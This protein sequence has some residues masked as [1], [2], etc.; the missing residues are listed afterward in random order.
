MPPTGL[1]PLTRVWESFGYDEI[2]WTYTPTG[3]RLL[4]T[5]ADF[6]GAQLPRPPALRLLLRQRLRH[7]AL[8]QRQRLP[9][10][11][12]RQ[13][14][15]R[16]HH[17]R[18]GLRRDRRRRS[19]R[20][21]RARL[22]SARPGAAGGRGAEG[23]AQPDRLHLLRGRH[24]GVPA[25]GLRQV[26]RPDRGARAALPGTLRRR[27]GH[28]LALG[29]VERARH[30]L[31]ARHAGTVQRAVHRHRASRSQR[32]TE[33]QG[34]RPDG[35]QRRPG[36]P[37]RASWTTPR[38]ERAAGLHLLPHQGMPLPDRGTTAR[39]AARPPSS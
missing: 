28:R 30:L 31:L 3:K 33:R 9:R 26:G 17:R 27:R 24:L 16:L 11:R 14:V 7:P 20:A 36:V 35:H 10:G 19:P 34:R 25:Q 32:A 23:G 5:F 37:A 6:S 38:A 29:A 8:G 2:N 21:R 12:G 15:L 18:P 39:P 1:G 13:P 22:H 4:K